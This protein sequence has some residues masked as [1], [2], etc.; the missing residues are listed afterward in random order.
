MVLTQVKHLI[1][2][3]V[4]PDYKQKYLALEKLKKAPR[5]TK[6]ST[7]IL[8][9]EIELVDS[10]S[11]LF[12]YK[13]IF[14]KGIYQF[15][16]ENKKP[17]IIDCGANIGLS[18]LYFKQLYP[19]SEIIA[20]EPDPQIFNILS[21]NV[22]NFNLS[23]VELIDKAVWNSET[24]LEFMSDG[25]DGGRVVAID[26][27]SQKYQV[28]TVKLRDYL[29]D[30]IDLL[31]IDIEGAETEVIEDCADLFHNV[32]NLFLEYHSFANKKQ[33]LPRILEILEK[34]GFRI[35]IQPGIISSQ[36]FLGRHIHCGMDMQ[37]N[38]FAFRE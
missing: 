19:E 4:K 27:A 32:K 11:F 8:G 35:H 9:K 6:T 18:V 7:F 13:E 15:P 16:C 5:Y 17:T 28:K 22:N 10:L 23:Q 31:K 26:S 3:V 12:M 34:A 25:A 20:F 38:I 1:K 29:N 33:T 24:T 2:L 36:P 37:L 14:E 21:N 30:N